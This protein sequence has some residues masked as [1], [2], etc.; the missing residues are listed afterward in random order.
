MKANLTATMNKEETKINFTLDFTGHGFDNH[1]AVDQ[2]AA[3][4][5]DAK[6]IMIYNQGRYT[7][8]VEATEE[9]CKPFIALA[10]KYGLEIIQ[11]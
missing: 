2:E 5:A 3:R 10:E 11:M 8:E 9:A 6:E 7:A 4:Y 1:D